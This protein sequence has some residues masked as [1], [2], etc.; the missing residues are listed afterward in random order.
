MADAMPSP[1]PLLQT[2]RLI[3]RV[4]SRDDFEAW[5]ALGADEVATRHIGGVQSRFATWNRLMATI[6][7]WHVLGF[8]G[9]SVIRRSDGRWIGRVGPLH[10]EGWP[11]DEIGWTL[12]R[13]AWGHGYATEAAAA[14]ADWA[15]ANLGW[16][17]IIHCIAPENAASQAVAMRLGSVRQGPGKLPAPYDKDPIEIWGQSRGEWFARRAQR[18]A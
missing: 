7:S 9:F 6:G 16:P 13:E 1:E 2:A 3:L 5:A 18:I 11:G 12:A 15:F 14:A 10:P 8:G 17:R 4:P